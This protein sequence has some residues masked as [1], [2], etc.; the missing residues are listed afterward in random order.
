MSEWQKAV[1]LPERQQGY[2][3]MTK[4]WKRGTSGNDNSLAGLVI[5]CWRASKGEFKG[6]EIAGAHLS[7]GLPLT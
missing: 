1:I 6:Q 4:E 7:N 3:A 2:A 5:V